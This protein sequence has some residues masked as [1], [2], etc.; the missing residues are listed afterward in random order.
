M[1]EH[2]EYTNNQTVIDTAEKI[3]CFQQGI[4]DYYN[5]HGR[6]GLPWRLTSDPWKLLL[7]EI[8]LRKTTS[9]QA[10]EVFHEIQNYAPEAVT[11]M[12]S[13]VLEKVLYPLGLHKIRA[14]GIK[15]IAR[16]VI[17]AGDEQYSSDEYLRSL[18]GVGRYI[19]NSVRC[20]AFGHAAPALD[21][22]MIRVI[23]RVFSV[24]SSRKRPREDSKLW[25]FAETLVPYDNAREF[26]WGVL[27][28]GA[29]VCTARNP[30]CMEC[31]LREICDYYNN[32]VRTAVA[33]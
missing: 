20:C 4:L 6:Y 1:S 12:D 16:L 28:L 32:Q 31:P 15:E 26:N 18:L 30:K 3:K 7:A 21:T 8:L 24:K 22:N 17:G 2:L 5:N 14:A 23:E 9:A 27:D 19:S 33:S 10:A 29:A 25:A 13:S 11:Q